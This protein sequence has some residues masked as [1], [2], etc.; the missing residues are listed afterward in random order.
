MSGAGGP[1]LGSRGAVGDLGT[2]LS[3]AG[4]PVWGCEGPQ[5]TWEVTT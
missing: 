4:G 2:V 1:L 3:G 5:G